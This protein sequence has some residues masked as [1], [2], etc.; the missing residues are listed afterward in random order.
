MIVKKVELILSRIR[1]KSYCHCGRPII[2]P[3]K[4]ITVINIHLIVTD[5]TLVIQS[6][7]ALSTWTPLNALNPDHKQNQIKIL[8]AVLFGSIT[9]YGTVPTVIPSLFF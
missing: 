3:P 4:P 1:M 6:L 9:L 5:H 2:N 7:P 8:T